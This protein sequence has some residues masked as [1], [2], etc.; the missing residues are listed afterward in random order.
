MGEAKR[1]ERTAAASITAEQRRAAARIDTRMKELDSAGLDE[2]E[3]IAAMK[4]YM[5]DFQDLTTGM[6]N[7]LMNVL[8]GK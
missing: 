4:D 8:C 1:G 6:T 5:S 3:I 2:V 7:P